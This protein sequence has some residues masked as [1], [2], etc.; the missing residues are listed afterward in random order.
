MPFEVWSTLQTFLRHR[1]TALP[2]WFNKVWVVVPYDREAFLAAQDPSGPDPASVFNKVFQVRFEVPP[3]LFTDTRNYLR[4]RLIQALPNHSAE[5]LNEI[6]GVYQLGRKQ[7]GYSPTPRELILFVNQVG[8]LHRVWA[9]DFPLSHLAYYALL[10]IHQTPMPDGLVAGLPLEGAFSKLLGEGYRENLAAITF[11]VERD[12]AV[13][14]LLQP[15]IIQAI[16]NREP[17]KLGALRSR[18]QEGF[19]E[20]L[21]DAMWP[22]PGRMS[23]ANVAYCLIE[24]NLL[25]G[26]PTQVPLIARRLRDL[27]DNDSWAG[28]DEQASNDFVAFL[29]ILEADGSIQQ[30]VVALRWV[31]GANLDW[32]SDNPGAKQALVKGLWGVHEFLGLCKKADVFDDGVVAEIE[33]RLMVPRPL[34]KP[35]LCTLLELLYWFRH[36]SAAGLATWGR[37]AER[38]VVLGHLHEATEQGDAE[39]IAL[40]MFIHL[41]SAPGGV[42]TGIYPWAP[43]LDRLNEIM[44]APQNQGSI[45]ADFARI[46]VRTGNLDLLSQIYQANGAFEPFCVACTAAIVEDGGMRQVVT[47]SLLIDEWRLFEQLSTPLEGPFRQLMSDLCASG[48]LTEEICKTGFDPPMFRLYHWAVG[49]GSVSDEFFEWLSSGLRRVTVQQWAAE[50]STQ[51]RLVWTLIKLASQGRSMDL[52]RLCDAL[53][54]HAQALAHGGA[55]SSSLVLRAD[56]ERELLF[57]VLEPEA[58]GRLHERLYELAKGANGDIADGF[59]AI[60]GGELRPKNLPIESRWYSDLFLTLLTRRKAGGLSWIGE[61]LSATIKPIPATDL[62]ERP[63]EERE[64]GPS[65]PV[66][67]FEVAIRDALAN[68]PGDDASEPIRKLAP[69]HP[70]ALFVQ[71]RDTQ[72]PAFG[73]WSVSNDA[74]D[75]SVKLS[76]GTFKR[77]LG[78]RHSDSKEP[79]SYYFKHK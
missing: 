20:V 44:V 25:E 32:T 1:S 56:E 45:P 5:E 53:L 68:D 70:D 26:A 22:G 59:F 16:A 38:G 8:A 47:A 3:L 23:A 60:F 10:R 61:T 33:S 30:G 40:C 4:D 71:D 67:Q 24:A 42:A 2:I 39:S 76:E 75:L 74:V 55:D 6:G 46:L 52:P 78:V 79:G 15:L 66:L 14:M 64:E 28:F 58:R 41:L 19:F 13:Q 49:S 77:Y 73:L 7:W 72:L 54:A 34:A 63:I 35:A 50:L 9:D 69:P 48:G 51:D 17:K 31:V 36:C 29:K 21:E 57:K 11:G 37:L 12:L 62:T 43:G 27:V 65:L 18:F